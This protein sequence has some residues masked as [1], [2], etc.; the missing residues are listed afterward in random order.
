MEIPG[1]GGEGSNVK[2]S[3][4]ENPGGV[5]VQTGK[6]PL[7]CMWGYGYFLEPHNLDHKYF[8]SLGQYANE[9]IQIISFFE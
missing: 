5:G 1:S 6:S 8:F 7:Y 9:F 3:G 4:I 2:P